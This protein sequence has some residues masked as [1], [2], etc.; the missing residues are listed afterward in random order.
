PLREPGVPFVGEQPVA[1]DARDVPPEP[2]VLD[3]VALLPDQHRLDQVRVVEHVADAPAQAERDDV[4]VLARGA[5]EGAEHVARELG[6]VAEQAMG[7]RPG[8]E[9][10]GPAVTTNES[11]TASGEPFRSAMKK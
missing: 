2:G 3:E 4:A 10:Q 6:Q 9:P 11:E 1:E 8:G 5:V 7:R